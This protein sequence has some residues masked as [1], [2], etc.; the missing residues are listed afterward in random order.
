MESIDRK[1][2]VAPGRLH[3]PLYEEIINQTGGGLMRDVVTLDT[4]ISRHLKTPPQPRI[5]L[6]YQY[7]Q[8][9]QDLSPE[10]DYYA[11]RQDYDFLSALLEFME[12]VQLNNI[13]QFPSATKKE[14]DLLEIIEKLQAIDLWQKEA[15]SMDLSQAKDTA[16]LRTGYP[17]EQKW[18]IDHLLKN[19]AVWLEGSPKENVQKRFYWSAANIRKAMELA[20]DTI[21]EEKMDA[22]QVYIALANPGDQQILA[23]IFE[24]RR[25]PVTF[26][27]QSGITPVLRQWQSAVSWMEEKSPENLELLLKTLYP[28]GSASLRRYRELFPEGSQLRDMVYEANPILSPDEFENLRSLEIQADT[29]KETLKG[30]ESWNFDT[31]STAGSAIQTQIP[32]P[33]KEDIKA[34]EQVANTFA[35]AESYIHSN[36]DLHLLAEEIRHM[37]L[38][39][40]L[41]SMEGC[42]VGSLK[43]ISP[44][45]PIVFFIGPSS[46]DFP[47]QMLYKGVFDEAYM[48]QL[49]LPG[50]DVRMKENEEESFALLSMPK[51]L[52]V[53]TAQSDYEGK[54][55]EPSHELTQWMGSMPLF[56]HVADS[57]VIRLPDFK[58]SEKVSRELFTPEQVLQVKPGPLKTFSDCPLKH[59]LKYK[60]RLEGP[61]REKDLLQMSSESLNLMMN[62]AQLRMQKNFWELSDDQL[63]MLLK[64]FFVFP[65]KVFPHKQKALD[66]L[67]KQ[68]EVKLLETAALLR[69]A[70]LQLDGHLQPGDY[71]LHLQED[72]DQLH[73][74]VSGEL[75]PWKKD[76]VTLNL[77][78][79]KPLEGEKESDRL[80]GTLQI[81][82]KIKPVEDK[83]SSILYGRG[84]KTPMTRVVKDQRQ[85]EAEFFQSSFSDAFVAQNLPEHAEETLFAKARKKP[86]YQK[87]EED[88]LE[89]ARTLAQDV[90]EGECQPLH[91]PD[92]C[93]FCP[94]SSICRNGAKER[95]K[96]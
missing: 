25:I 83:A 5:A 70:A 46:A 34:F 75:S 7:Q 73:I 23:Q 54:S 18:W 29:W 39:R 21:V 30:L 59:M 69:T 17:A 2:I 15:A 91:R 56:R 67:E 71:Q 64:H 90:H 93:K 79:N 16:I 92:A 60:A 26:L 49:D 74:E 32:S 43:E 52:F 45:R 13:T 78:R 42:L 57:S 4:W 24:T 6:L 31:F 68:Y 12:M 94:Y 48:R 37:N 76:S 88:L 95:G 9:L 3:L 89:S 40:S 20:A 35:Q 47:G 84:N 72:A 14:K 66:V 63:K 53:I 87:A 10:N 80:Y 81:S 11:S 96:E 44:L 19:G 77:V 50:L 65:R 86:T 41:D 22:S 8:A 51:E 36:E 33:T 85:K 61:R 28:R 82:T 1:L 38:S 27:H 55:I 58:L 62:D